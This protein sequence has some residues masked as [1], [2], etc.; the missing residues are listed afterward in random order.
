M[1]LWEEFVSVFCV[2]LLFVVGEEDHVEFSWLLCWYLPR[3][4]DIVAGG[5]GFVPFCIMN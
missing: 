1:N 5:S 4:A 2:F 3:I